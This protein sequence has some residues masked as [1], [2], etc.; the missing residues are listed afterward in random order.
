[1]PITTTLIGFEN[2]SRLLHAGFLFNFLI[3]IVHTKRATE[4]GDV[5]LHVTNLVGRCISVMKQS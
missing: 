1:M 5:S 3:F 2:F 4:I